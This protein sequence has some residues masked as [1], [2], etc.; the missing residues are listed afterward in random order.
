MSNV[1]SSA[2]SNEVQQRFIG[3]GY[4][5]PLKAITHEGFS[6]NMTS[7][8]TIFGQLNISGVKRVFLTQ[9]GTMLS[10]RWKRAPVW[11]HLGPT[12]P[13][14][15]HPDPRLTARAPPG[16]LPACQFGRC[17]CCAMWRGHQ[18][19]Q[20]NHDRVPAEGPW[21]LLLRPGASVSPPVVRRSVS[22][23]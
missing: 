14:T 18:K 20:G 5:S 7:A 21:H 11:S 1:T 8:N 4:F 15:D 22:S 12:A 16:P 3:L 2:S 17:T 13:P 23:F 19:S 10:V 6:E 9:I